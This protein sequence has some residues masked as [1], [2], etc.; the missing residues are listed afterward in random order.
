MS[1]TPFS[2]LQ[3]HIIAKLKNAKSLRYSE[4]MPEYKVQNDLFNYHLQFLVKK[5]FVEKTEDGYMLSDIGVKHV[6]DPIVADSKIITSLYKMN[7]ITIASRV[8]DGEIQILNQKRTSNPSFGKVGVMGGVVWKGEYNVDAAVRKLKIETGL[9]ATDF[10]LVG[11][12]RRI[13]Y[14]GDE[15]FSD[16]LFPIAYTKSVSGKLIEKTEYGENMWVPINEAIEN[17]SDPFDSIEMITT[18][19]K[20]IK[21]GSIDTMPFLFKEVVKKGERQP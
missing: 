10:K 16:V 20:A 2:P 15:I 1:Q 8:L 21:D 6:A 13:M 7:V 14:V 9:D 4:L 12:E 19:L 17:E 3:N 11:M 18:V 5:G